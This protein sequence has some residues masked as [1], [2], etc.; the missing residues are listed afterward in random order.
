MV[1]RYHTADCEQDL[2][3][4]SWDTLTTTLR[5]WEKEEEVED[6]YRID[7][8]RAIDAVLFGVAAR[9]W[10]QHIDC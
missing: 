1:T 4:R 2:S 5:A 3:E 8:V 7:A 10:D 9:E 6:F